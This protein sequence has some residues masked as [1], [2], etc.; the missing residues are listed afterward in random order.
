MALSADLPK[1]VL[2]SDLARLSA[3]MR[4]DGARLV[5]T[6]GCFDIL[7]AG[8]VRYLRRAR[9]LGDALVVGLNSDASVARLKGPGRPINSAEDRAEVLAGLTAVDYVVVFDDD[10]ATS[11]VETIKPAV[12]VKGGDYSGDRSSPRFPPEGHAALAN[13]GA[14]SIVDLAPGRSTSQILRR[15]TPDMPG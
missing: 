7:H 9:D 6:N 13:G 3:R 14:V 1:L 2:L 12:Y 8:H 4:A 10:T 11:V 5:F 15:R